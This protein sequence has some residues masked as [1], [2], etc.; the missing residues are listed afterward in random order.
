MTYRYI[1]TY[2]CTYK[3]YTFVY[4]NVDY[5]HQEHSLVREW[6]DSQF[7]NTREE[8]KVM[9]FWIVCL[10]KTIILGRS[11]K[12]LKNSSKSS[13]TP[14]PTR[15]RFSKYF[16]SVFFPDFAMALQFSKR[17]VPKR[18]QVSSVF[19]SHSLPSCHCFLYFVLGSHIRESPV[20]MEN[21]QSNQAT[22]PQT[23]GG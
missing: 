4:L 12:H 21:L 1:Y 20:W 9:K 6:N 14:S 16:L 19:G 18:S 10:L 13:Q 17:K 3:I 5:H 2:T 11:N 22:C 8:V 7:Q 23:R 15:Q